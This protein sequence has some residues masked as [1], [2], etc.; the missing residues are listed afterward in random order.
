[1]IIIKG[2]GINFDDQ[3]TLVPLEAKDDGHYYELNEVDDRMRHRCQWPW[4]RDHFEEEFDCFISHIQKLK[5]RNDLTLIRHNGDEQ[6]I[7]VK[8]ERHKEAP[9]RTN[10]VNVLGRWRLFARE[11]GFE[12][13]KLIRFK[14]M[15]EVEDLEAENE[16]DMRYPV[17]HLC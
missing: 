13:N 15:H 12:Y 9:E 11:N 17:F 8:M 14:Y 2:N 3:F 5:S 10:H 1:M 7:R 6:M 16:A 4:H